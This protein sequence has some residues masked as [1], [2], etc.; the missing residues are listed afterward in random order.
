VI[1][2]DH[3]W[4]SFRN[5]LEVR[6]A[7]LK[8]DLHF[9]EKI[10]QDETSA[11]AARAF[12]QVVRLFE[13]QQPAG[14]GRKAGEKRSTGENTEIFG[15]SAGRLKNGHVA[16]VNEGNCYRMNNKLNVGECGGKE[17]PK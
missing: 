9:A 14:E 15:A 10:F 8:F 13:G 16:I 3:H 12:V 4:T 11:P 5:A 6:G 1:G 2:H 17:A 7:N